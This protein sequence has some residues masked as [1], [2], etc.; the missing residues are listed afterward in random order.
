MNYLT[1]DLYK[2]FKCI[3]SA[4]PNTCCAGW[5]IIIDEAT[6]KKMA[7]HE[8]QNWMYPPKTG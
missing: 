8:E 1:V 2:D 5:R 3:A 6:C 4:C 7:E